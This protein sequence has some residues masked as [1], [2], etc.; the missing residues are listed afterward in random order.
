MM[1]I[2]GLGFAW[3]ADFMTF[4]RQVLHYKLLE[5]KDKGRKK[6]SQTTG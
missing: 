3:I 2:I 1:K 6:S 5:G 4:G